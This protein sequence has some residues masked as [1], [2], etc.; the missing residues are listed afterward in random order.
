MSTN[1][2]FA[3]KIKSNIYL[4]YKNK[5]FFNSL[6]AVNEKLK[7]L[8]LCHT[9]KPFHLKDVSTTELSLSISEQGVI[10][11][12]SKQSL[13]NIP[14]HKLL[15]LDLP[16]IEVEDGDRE[17]ADVQ[18]ESLDPITEKHAGCL[19]DF[20][21][22]ETKLE[23]KRIYAKKTWEQIESNAVLNEFKNMIKKG[24]LPGKI[25]CEKCIEKYSFLTNRKWTDI[26]YHVKNH[27]SKIN[28]VKNSAQSVCTQ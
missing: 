24:K 14:N 6:S 9:L 21:E 11:F 4:N 13:M 23:K 8:L 15:F 22:M 26:K 17:E 28:K 1:Y 5:Y 10:S 19:R 27:I 18:N 20:N 7:I 3:K 2:E 25:D 12:S 16:H